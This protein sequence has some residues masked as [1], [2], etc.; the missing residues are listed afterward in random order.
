[1]LPVRNGWPLVKE[2]VNSILAQ[3][4][5]HFELLIL[6]NFSND[7]TSQWLDT[8]DDKRIKVSRSNKYLNIV[9][10]WSR[11]LD[12]KKNEFMTMIGHDDILFP[13]FLSTVCQLI[14]NNGEA[15]L[16][17]TSG[18]FINEDGK[19]LRSLRLGETLETSEDYLRRRFKFE[20]DVSGTGYV[21]RS[22][23]FDRVGGIPAFESL[24][25]ADDAL[26]ILMMEDSFK[27]S[28]PKELYSIRQHSHS[29]AASKPSRW[30][31][32]VPALIQF[33][34]FLNYHKKTDDGIQ[35]VCEKYSEHFFLYILQKT[36]IY[37]LIE[38]SSSNKK[39]HHNVV[40]TI[41][42]AL[43]ECAP[44]SNKELE[45]LIELRVLK[46]LN[47]SYLRNLIPMLW[48]IYRILKQPKP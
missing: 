3:K 39:I 28:S 1:V 25:Y 35:R 19:Y 26:W 30:K 6:D 27:V 48:R 29:E 38:A 17:Y 42:E 7:G 13:D 12:F 21:M 4:Y 11:I 31:A 23:D 24:F 41:K 47:S 43:T 37:A 34:K 22:A 46:Y 32:D 40:S 18:N 9:E 44:G 10:S 2:C 20:I 8:L 36:Y 45:D 16:Y 33:H 5:P 14:K 15:G